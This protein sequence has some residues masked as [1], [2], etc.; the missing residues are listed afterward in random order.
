MRNMK[1]SMLACVL[2][3]GAA[4]ADDPAANTSTEVADAPPASVELTGGAVA[5]GIGYTWGHGEITYQGARH[6]FSISGISLV[7]VGVVNISASGTAYHLGK[8]DDLNGNYMAASV[9]LTLAGGGDALVLK[10]EHG[11]VIKLLSTDQ[12]LRFNLAGSGISVKLES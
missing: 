12:G 5:A 2:V 8:L 3:T 11:V 10:N 7:D 6:R 4:F 1:V 9:G